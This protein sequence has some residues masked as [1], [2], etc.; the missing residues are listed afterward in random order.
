M[1]YYPEYTNIG[2][3]VVNLHKKLLFLEGKSF[4]L[5]IP[6]SNVNVDEWIEVE[7]DCVSLVVEIRE[8]FVGILLPSGIVGWI[9]SDWL[10][11]MIDKNFI[12]FVE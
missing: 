5:P 10:L 11:T 7:T 8:N 2:C 9:A 12:R 4:L 3:R 6:D 1:S